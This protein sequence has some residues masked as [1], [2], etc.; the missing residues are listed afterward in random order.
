MNRPTV[1]ILTRYEVSAKDYQ[2]DVLESEDCSY[3]DGRGYRGNRSVTVSGYT[4]QSWN[5]QC[6][7][8]HNINGNIYKAIR[9]SGN[10]CRN[11]GGFAKDGPWCFTTNRTVRWEYCDVPKCAKQPPSSPPVNFQGH[12]VSSTSINAT[13]GDVPKPHVHGILLGFRVTCARRNTSDRHFVDLAPAVHNWAFKGLEKFRNYSCWLRAYNHFGNGTWSEELVIS[14]D[15]DVPDAPPASL[16]AWNLS[17][18]SLHVQWN[19]IPFGYR[20][21]NILRYKVEIKPDEQTRLGH[22]AIHY[23]ESRSLTISGLQKYNKYEIRVSGLTRRG[24]GPA[25]LLTV[26]TDEDGEKTR[27]RMST[28]NVL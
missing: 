23:T 5:A 9:D 11:P 13:W 27:T 19:P 22:K 6:P 2:L 24:E 15:E 10:L 14:T 28:L 26:Q 17:S 8:K 3:G 21:G 7:H 18:T 1:T 16:T 25:R 4:C 12:N 20:H